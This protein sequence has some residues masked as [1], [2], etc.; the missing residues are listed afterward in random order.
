MDKSQSKALCFLC[1]ANSFTWGWISSY[2]VQPTTFRTDDAGLG[3]RV[4]GLGGDRTRAR[5][6]DN[7]GNVLLFD[8]AFVDEN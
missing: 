4:F 7:C 6:C 1:G 8:K 2:G 3:E 5:R